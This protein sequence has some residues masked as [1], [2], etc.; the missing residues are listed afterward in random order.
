METLSSQ[1]KSFNYPEPNINMVKLEQFVEVIKRSSKKYSTQV[2]DLFDICGI[3][4]ANLNKYTRGG[5]LAES[6]RFEL[7]N[8]VRSEMLFTGV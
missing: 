8:R 4:T 1:G 2:L 5:V 3:N 6:K 7:S